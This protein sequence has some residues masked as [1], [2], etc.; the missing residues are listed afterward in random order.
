MMKRALQYCAGS[1][2]LHWL[3]AL[4]VISMLSLS[5]F[6]SDLAKDYQ[7]SA[8]LIHKSF[9]LTVLGLMIL[10]VIWIF[11]GGK[12]RLPDTVPM[13]QQYLARFV[14]NLLYFFLF[15]MPLTGWVMSVAAGRVP[16][17]FGLFPVPLPIQPDKGLAETMSIMH[18]AIA[19]TLIFLIVLHIAGA[20]KHYIINKD[21][22]LQTMLPKR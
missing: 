8:Y 10:R 14:Q 17:Y 5:F 7:P 4:I 15:A 21:Q 11:K 18:T 3:I 9:G 6:L 19:W 1:K 2:V 16:N 12:P 13:W 20:L 22:V